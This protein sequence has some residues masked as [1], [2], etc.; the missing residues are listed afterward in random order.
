MGKLNLSS[1]NKSESDSEWEDFSNTEIQ[2]EENVDSENEEKN[3]I[4]ND[5]STKQDILSEAK[6]A[7]LKKGLSIK[8]LK[9][10]EKNLKALSVIKAIN[11]P[12]A[13][14]DS[15]K[16][17]NKNLPQNKPEI[18]DYATSDEEDLRNTIGKF[19]KKIMKNLMHFIFMK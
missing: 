4:K 17:M 1:E 5:E 7:S 16:K 6:S 14:A 2:K 19:K 18:D 15:I 3:I 8:K 13:K 9:R 10:K 11:V 12:K